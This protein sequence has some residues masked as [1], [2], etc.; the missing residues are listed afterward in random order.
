LVGYLCQP[1]EIRGEIRKQVIERNYPGQLS[2]AA[3]Y[4]RSSYRARTHATNRFIDRIL[5]VQYQRIGRHDVCNPQLG[6]V[7]SSIQL[8][9]DDV[10]IRENA[11]DNR[12]IGWGGSHNHRAHTVLAHQSRC[13]DDRCRAGDAYYVVTAQFGDF[14]IS[15]GAIRHVNSAD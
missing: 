11:N 13:F 5:F 6:Q 2:A 1:G 9:T 3:D 4:G 8:G 14:H 15:L 7:N 10:T 12:T